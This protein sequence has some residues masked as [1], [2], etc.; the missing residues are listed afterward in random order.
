MAGYSFSKVFNPKPGWY[1]GDFHVH[2][3]ASADGEH[4][5]STVAQLAKNEKLDF[6]TFTDHNSI[7]GFSELNENL[8]YPVIP[9]I[10]ITLDEGHFNVF[11]MGD[12]RPWMEG[13]YGK[14]KAV[15]LPSRY[16]DVNELMHQIGQEGFINSIDHPLLHPWEWQFKNTDLH[17]VQCLEVWNDLYWP[18]N[19]YANP[20]TVDLWTDWL[21][22]GFRVVAI[23]GS[24]YHYPPKPEEG[25]PGE[26]LGQPTTYVYAEALSGPAILNG[27]RQGRAYVSKGPQID[28]RVTSG[29]NSYMIGDDLGEQSGEIEFEATIANQAKTARIQLIKN[30]NIIAEESFTGEE[31]SVQF[32]GSAKPTFPAWYRIDV[33]DQKGDALLIT[34]PIYVNKHRRD[35]S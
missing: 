23:G 31:S 35:V 24:D 7:E 30:G 13:I 4:S 18:D 8:D 21:N 5:P 25:L 29:I 11:G 22:A 17:N 6:V 28:Y 10:E 27:I 34:N 1:C 26:R 33:L 20:K 14:Q 16:K 32:R 12:K 19:A 15:P 2:T 9:G 3:N